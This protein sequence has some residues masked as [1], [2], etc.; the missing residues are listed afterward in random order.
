MAKGK[1]IKKIFEG[2]GRRSRKVQ[3][4][5]AKI[6]EHGGKKGSPYY[7]T[8]PKGQHKSIKKATTKRYDTRVGK[9]RTKQGGA[10]VGG[11]AVVTLGSQVG[12]D[13]PVIPA[14]QPKVPSGFGAAFR[15]AR[16]D[17]L[18]DRSKKKTFEWDGN[19]YHVRIKGETPAMLKTQRDKTLSGA[20]KKGAKTTTTKT[21]KRKTF[22]QRR[23]ERLKKR[24]A[25]VAKRKNPLIKG[26]ADKLKK[27]ISR[28]EKKADGGWIGDLKEAAQKPSQIGT[29]IKKPV[30]VKSKKAVK[31]RRP[32][33]K[34]RGGIGRPIVDRLPIMPKLPSGKLPSPRR[35]KMP[36]PPEEMRDLGLRNR[37]EKRLVRA[38][39]PGAGKQL[40]EAVRRSRVAKNKKNMDLPPKRRQGASIKGY[41]GGGTVVRRSPQFQAR[42]RGRAGSPYLATNAN[43]PINV[44]QRPVGM[45]KG[46]TPKKQGYDARLHESLGARH[47]GKK[48][49]S[50]KSRSNESKGAEKAAGKRAYASVTTMD[51]GTRKAK[52]RGV[53]VAKRGYGK[54]LS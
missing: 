29:R 21:T 26:R 34:L 16:N 2:I 37:P 12:K 8:T 19:Q 1:I 32:K 14:Q 44:R 23:L 47:P 9:T 15:K 22:K 51:K 3:G 52:P 11:A 46:G 17:Y 49:Q 38:M 6:L 10:V 48:T 45:T 28:L 4:K 41:Q 13:K 35:R 36:P 7:K 24:Q 33:K 27:R 18:N 39:K 54:A 42:R 40:E 30:K 31:T 20:F 43:E 25:R 50:L 53:G 5:K